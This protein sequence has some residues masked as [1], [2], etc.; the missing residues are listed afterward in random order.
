M[1]CPGSVALEAT[2]PAPPPSPHAEEGTEAH[3]WAERAIEHAM[4]TEAG[5]T[6]NPLQA[7]G[8]PKDMWEPL[9][10]YVN[11]VTEVASR[12]GA[13]LALEKRLSLEPLNPPSPMFG[14]GDALVWFED[15]K[16]LHV[17]DL[18]YGKGVVVEAEYNPQLWYYALA[19][20]VTLR[21]APDTI[22]VTVIQPR[23]YHEAGPIRSQVIEWEELVNWKKVLF[24]AAERTTKPDAG[25]EPGSWCRWCRAHAVCP[26]QRDLAVEV[27]RSQ[28]DA[29]VMPAVPSPDS[30]TE[31]ELAH[32]LKHA[33]VI[34]AWLKAVEERAFEILYTGQEIT[35]FKLVEKRATRRWADD[36]AA[37]KYLENLIGEDAYERSMISPAKAEKVLKGKLPA[38]LVEKH[39][40]G[41]TMAPESDKRPGVTAPGTEIFLL[42]TGGS[43][44]GTPEKG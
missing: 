18:K 16:E 1:Q 11:Y 14:T 23:A 32:V 5:R 36:S 40:S 34:Q 10:V 12:P 25:Y 30:L 3:E 6:L 41:L 26:A 43:D 42:G 33:S 28:F 44:T 4:S 2:I 37:A 17:I 29:E 24:A 19:A 35:G 21:V 8:A 7:V 31:D 38:E 27:A 22:H 9:D 20:A 39:S 15:K 13:V